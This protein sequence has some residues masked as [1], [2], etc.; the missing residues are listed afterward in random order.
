MAAFS[1]L[2]NVDFD[3][4]RVVGP[5]LYLETA[6][7]SAQSIIANRRLE[8]VPGPFVQTEDEPGQAPLSDYVKINPVM[9]DLLSYMM[10]TAER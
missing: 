6:Q 7:E 4:E 8:W 5:Q 3:P 2:A 1:T 9:F 10:G